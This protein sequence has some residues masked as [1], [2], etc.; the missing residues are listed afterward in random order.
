MIEGDDIVDGATKE[1]SRKL[2]IGGRTD[3]GCLHK[4]A[5]SNYKEYMDKEGL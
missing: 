2:E 3:L 4:L 5:A 1:P